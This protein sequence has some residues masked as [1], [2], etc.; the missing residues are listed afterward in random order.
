VQAL[1]PLY[2]GRLAT[3]ASLPAND[4]AAVQQQLEALGQE[5]ERSRPYL[6]DR[7]GAAG[8]R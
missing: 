3:I 7:W 2:L 1:V 4:D 5:L 6:V 8:G